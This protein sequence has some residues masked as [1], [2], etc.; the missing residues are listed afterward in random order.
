MVVIRE[1][2]RHI[3]GRCTGGVEE[4]EEVREGD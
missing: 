2:R 4:Q 3:K 1:T